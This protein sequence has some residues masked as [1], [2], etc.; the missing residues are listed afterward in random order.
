MADIRRQV[1]EFARN[2]VGTR[3]WARI[4]QYEVNSRKNPIRRLPLTSTYQYEG[5]SFSCSAVPSSQEWK[6]DTFHIL[7]DR[8]RNNDLSGKNKIAHRKCNIGVGECW[9]L[10]YAALQKHGG[11]TR[12]SLYLGQG[13]I[14]SNSTI[15]DLSL[16]K[17]GEILELAK[18]TYF[19]K[20]KYIEQAGRL[21]N[22]EGAE[23]ESI[24]S[25]TP[26]TAIV[27][28][29]LKN[30][31]I[32]QVYHQNSNNNL[33]VHEGTFGVMN[34]TYS[35]NGFQII[36]LCGG[37]KIKEIYLKIDR[38]LKN[39]RFS[40]EKKL[41]VIMQIIQDCKAL[42]NSRNNRIPAKVKIYKPQDNN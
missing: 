20:I 4:Y 8:N 31:G 11:L 18:S 19:L 28:D 22:F 38:T 27:K 16:V 24:S 30:K 36:Q 6:D 12:L 41:D 21:R 1:L 40:N 9:D 26:H 17:G 10:A 23:I 13:R 29:T 33:L 34:K 3:V 7:T 39:N 35:E 5:Q 32:L 37:N 15:N 14:W 42:V 25:T 2:A